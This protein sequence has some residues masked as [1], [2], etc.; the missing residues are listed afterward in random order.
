MEMTPDEKRIRIGLINGASWQTNG[1]GWTYL[2]FGKTFDPIDNPIDRK[3]IVI[4]NSVPNYPKDLNAIRNAIMSRCSPERIAI[5]AEL[6]KIAAAKGIFLVEC[7][8]EMWADAFLKVFASE[9]GR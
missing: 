3:K 2:S 9:E 7:S 8:A 1:S 5:Q 6:I 4:S